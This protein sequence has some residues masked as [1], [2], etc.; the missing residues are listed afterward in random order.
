MLP[1]PS[2]RLEQVTAQAGEGRGWRARA[3]WA[4]VGCGHGL[5]AS[6]EDIGTWRMR[7]GTHLPRADAAQ[8][9]LDQDGSF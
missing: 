3:A 8:M 4:L 6:Q 7:L 2:A 5:P 1:G 9:S